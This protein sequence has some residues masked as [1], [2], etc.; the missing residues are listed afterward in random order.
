[1]TNDKRQPVVVTPV[2]PTKWN[3]Q[4]ID[5]IKRTVAADTNRDEFDLFIEVCKRVGLDP[6]RKQIYAVVYSKNNKDKRKMSIITGID[7]FRAIAARC[8]DYRPAE[9]PPRIEYDE[10]ERTPLNPKGIVSAMV[11]VYKKSDGEW[12]PVRA[13]AYWDEYAPKKQVWE[14]GQPTDEQKLS[15][16]WA[17]MP[18]LMI[19]K[20]AEA[21]ALRMGWPEDMAGIYTDDEMARTH[22]ELTASEQVEKYEAEARMTAIGGKDSIAFMF[23]YGQPLELVPIGE[24]ADRVLAYIRG[25]NHP[26]ELDMFMQMNRVGLQQFWAA[27]KSDALDLKAALEKERARMERAQ[28]ED[29]GDPVTVGEEG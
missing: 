15:E 1:M 11:T 27:A 26:E 16:M 6:F 12:S 18:R 3:D 23:G 22:E 5:L 2:R 28:A 13:I 4:Q 20:V 7:G 8:G 24:L 9:D 29:K 14:N 17:K 21:L 19:G 25:V 10:N